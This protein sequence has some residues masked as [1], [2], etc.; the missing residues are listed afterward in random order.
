MLQ[1]V[2]HIAECCTHF[3]QLLV[4]ERKERLKLGLSDV[5]PCAPTTMSGLHFKE[6]TCIV[7]PQSV[8][9]YVN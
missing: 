3:S 9:S 4:L 5:A 1:S 7:S 8:G 6:D 2:A